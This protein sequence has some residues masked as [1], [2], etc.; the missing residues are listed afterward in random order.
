MPIYIFKHP[1]KEEYVE[2]FFNMNDEKFFIDKEGMKWVREFSASN[3]S[4]TYRTFDEKRLVDKK[5]NPYRIQKFSEKFVR[6]QGFKNA[7]DYIDYNNAYMVDENK[8]PDR[9]IEKA[10]EQAADKDLQSKIAHNKSMQK[11]MVKKIQK[12]KSSTTIP[13]SSVTFSTDSAGKVTKVDKK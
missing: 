3:L 11:E 5:G 2:V 9:N 1:D 7:T 12:A 10:H 4:A 6:Q 8:T 13:N